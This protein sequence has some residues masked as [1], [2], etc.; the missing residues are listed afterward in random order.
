MASTFSLQNSVEGA[1]ADFDDGKSSE[2]QTCQLI[3]TILEHDNPSDTTWQEYKKNKSNQLKLIG[4]QATTEGNNQRAISYFSFAILLD[5]T[6]YLFYS[7]RSA[8]FA[9]LGKYYEALNDAIATVKLNP[10]W[11]KVRTKIN[12]NSIG[13]FETR[14]G[15]L[16]SSAI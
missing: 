3:K 10:S 5:P 1:I 13:I 15:S 9:N 6:Q 8:C 12:S 11:A 7:N 16:F 4:N 2:D 14:A